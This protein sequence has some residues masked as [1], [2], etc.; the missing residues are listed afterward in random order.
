MV[1]KQKHL[2]LLSFFL[3]P[4]PIILKE[5]DISETGYVSV[6]L[7]KLKLAPHKER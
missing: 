1:N 4:T 7:W 5:H 2:R 6:Y 3:C